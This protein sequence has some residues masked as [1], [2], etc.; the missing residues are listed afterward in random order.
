MQWAQ[1][2]DP[3]GN[4]ALSFA[5]ACIPLLF[6]FWCLA[7]KKMKG[8][9]AGLLTV[10]VAV[11]EAIV[12]YHMPVH[13]ALEATV[14]GGLQGLWPIGWIVVT[15]VFL[16]ELTVA[17]G[18]FQ[19][20]SDSIASI[21]EDRRLQA[22][23][24]AFSFGAFLEGTA[25]YGTPVAIAGG[26]LAGLGFNP[27]YAAGL[28]LIANTAP[29]AFGGVGIPILTSAQ[30]TGIDTLSLSQMV[31]R[32]VPFLSLFVP[33][34]L[35]FIMSGWKR[36]LEVFP[37]ILVSGLS[38]AGTQYLTAN[39]LGPELP[40]VTSAI[41]SMVSL[42][43]LLKF[44]QPKTIFRFKG[45]KKQES[46]DRDERKP[47]QRLGQIVQAWSPFVLLV[48]VICIWGGSER[49]KAFL[50]QATLLL[51][52]PG[53]DQ[54][55]AQVKPIV[56]QATPY[57]A[58]YKFDGLAATGTAILVTCVLSKFLI[59]ISWKKWGATF[60]LT[61]KKLALPLVMIVSVL[62]FAY[63]E[64][65]SGMSATLGLGLASTGVVFPFLAPFIGWIGV[66]LTGSDTSSNALF[67]NLQKVSANQIGVDPTLLVAANSTG[68][69]AAKMISPQ[70]IAVATAATGLVGKE[71]SLFRFTILH[72]LLFV[73]ITGV[74]TFLQAYVLQWMIP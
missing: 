66:F 29:V 16:Y 69:V 45:E 7:I 21:T 24:I 10:A 30:V 67:S 53:L 39:F 54:M 1:N 56:T 42:V 33:F 17:S 27:F 6:F 3:M 46:V 43:L 11:L 8:Y 26:L 73:A 71:G 47:K 5:V 58:V 50:N 34:W 14:L 15:A 65:Y 35:V 63:I 61:I 41:V 44:W 48:L 25:G 70:S 74:I 64:N 40:D 28:C 68:G 12:V 2:Y 57:G 20:I 19:V 22:L 52:I 18:K 23:L 59:G 36:T 32:Q 37:A 38:F 13:L 4:M 9:L 62:G 49:I 31:G 55:I 51:P 72:S 60:G